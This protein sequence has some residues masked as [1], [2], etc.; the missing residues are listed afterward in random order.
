MGQSTLLMERMELS[1]RGCRRFV[2]CAVGK[3]VCG[4]QA[5]VVWNDWQRGE[6]RLPTS[7]D[8]YMYDDFH[9]KLL[10]RGAWSVEIE[11]YFGYYIEACID[12]HYTHPRTN[13]S[14][15]MVKKKRESEHCWQ[16]GFNT[17]PDGP[18]PGAADDFP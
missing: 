1:N 7:I 3:E 18:V 6:L 2:W 4:N 5:L 11:E 9:R 10:D 16:Y 13:Q 12:T 17:P 8:A 15:S 14:R